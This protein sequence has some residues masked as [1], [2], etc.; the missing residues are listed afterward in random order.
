MRANLL[1][2]V[3]CLV[4]F[5]VP[6]AA[7]SIKVEQLGSAQQYDVGVLDD[8]NGGLGQNLWQGTSAKRAIY[9]LETLDLR[10]QQPLV[11]DIV[12]SVVL[13]GGVPPLAESEAE[14]KAYAL[15]RLKTIFDLGE[16]GAAQ[17]IVKRTPVL[18]DDL[19]LTADMALMAGDN[20]AACAIADGVVDGRG[21]PVWARLRAFCHVLRAEI[22]A[23]EV[24][25]DILNSSGYEDPAY[26]SLMRIISRA[27]GDPDLEDL[28]SDDA[29]HVALMAQAS[30]EWPG[31]AP[32]RILAARRALSDVSSAENRLSALYAAGPALSDAQ[33]SRVLTALAGGAPQLEGESLITLD[34]ALN[35]PFP[36]GTGQLWMI[37]QTGTAD[38]RPKAA[39]ELLHRAD[40]AGAFERVAPLLAPAI[41]S[42]S[43]ESQA[44]TNAKLFIRAAVR[45]GDIRLLQD[46]HR[47]LE[48][49]PRQQAR[50]ALITDALGFGFLAGPVGV[51]I[52]TRLQG[53]ADVKEQAERD[54][55][56]A[57]A[58]GATLS[59][60]DAAELVVLGQ[61]PG[62]VIAPGLGLAID[63]AAYAGTRAETAL[64][65]AHILSKGPLNNHDMFRVISALNGVGLTQI[66]GRIAAE[67]FLK[68]F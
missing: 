50:I 51:D 65:A 47:T 15:M 32:S 59:D 29:L 62:Y 24:T 68:G 30:L 22:P 40:S 49:N 25:T 31:K 46:M 54:I 52:E 7:Q 37:A 13:S 4:G 34:E 21:E 8:A 27:S 58:M 64:W 61:G 6:A 45:R 33:M 19:Q 57:L 35:A 60:L 2:I 1:T 14:Q 56:I 38:E 16:M 39:A 48:E 67:D 17:S 53:E 42:L 43:P 3:C 23:A 20:P 12:R 63:A 9:L 5:T 26:F 66:S 44:L 10:T 11:A 41:Q 55:F 36:K 28:R 18:A